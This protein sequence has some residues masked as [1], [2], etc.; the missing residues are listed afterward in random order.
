MNLLE[1]QQRANILVQKVNDY[2]ASLIGTEIDETDTLN[3]HIYADLYCLRP[4]MK[5]LFGTTVDEKLNRTLDNDLPLR[6]FASSAPAWNSTFNLLSVGALDPIEIEPEN[7]GVGVFKYTTNIQ[8]KEVFEVTFTGTSVDR[9][10]ALTAYGVNILPY[11][12]YNE[13]AEYNYKDNN[14]NILRKFKDRNPSSGDILSSEPL[15][16]DILLNDICTCTYKFTGLTDT[17][18]QVDITYNIQH[19]T[20][21]LT[22]TISLHRNSVPKVNY[23][24]I[25]DRN[26]NISK[27]PAFTITSKKCIKYL[28]TGTVDYKSDQHEFVQDIDMWNNNH[29]TT[30][31]VQQNTV[32]S[33]DTRIKQGIN[34]SYS[35]NIADALV[36]ESQVANI[37][38][39]NT[40]HNSTISNN[41]ITVNRQVPGIVCYYLGNDYS[42]VYTATIPYATGTINSVNYSTPSYYG[43][44]YRNDDISKSQVGLEPGAECCRIFMPGMNYTRGMLISPQQI[45][46]P[47]KLVGDANLNKGY[48]WQGQAIYHE[49][50]FKNRR[51][52]CSDLGLDFVPTL[53]NI[54]DNDPQGLA[55]RFALAQQKPYYYNRPWFNELDD[56]YGQNSTKL[57]NFINNNSIIIPETTTKN[58]L[59]NWATAANKVSIDYDTGVMTIPTTGQDYVGSWIS[60]DKSIIANNQLTFIID[61][62]TGSEISYGQYIVNFGGMFYINLE[63]SALRTRNWGASTWVTFK[64]GITAN[65]HYKI[66]VTITTGQQ[67]FEEINSDGTAT[68]LAVLDDTGVNFNTGS[69]FLIGNSS[70]SYFFRGSINL[71]NT[72]VNNNP[73]IHEVTVNPVVFDKSLFDISEG[74]TLSDEGILSPITSSTGATIINENNKL[75][76]STTK[77][78]EIYSPKIYTS[79]YFNS[80]FQI[81]ASNNGYITA[82]VEKEADR[83]GAQVRCQLINYLFF[84]LSVYINSSDINWV[85]FKFVNDVTSKTFKVYARS[86]KTE[87]NWQLINDGVFTV[88]EN[89]EEFTLNRYELGFA[90][91]DDNLKKLDL[92]PIKL[93]VEGETIF[94]ASSVQGITPMND[95][96]FYKQYKLDYNTWANAL[97]KPL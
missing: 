21:G 29:M 69:P 53:D 14:S 8:P 73:I 82:R 24:T 79:S 23:F 58:E 62:T 83:A 66:K 81:G 88:D 77:N 43:A 10:I 38:K 56:L 32:T 71:I 86:D 50:V 2:E 35:S 59:Q 85:Q 18:M 95:E 11:G 44:Y 61:F 70:D 46:Q 17:T 5:L 22:E 16:E 33:R 54:A 84:D 90:D 3:Q 75:D 47:D 93:I 25:V 30:L 6:V 26:N 19:V 55:T 13:L 80:P 27:Y 52:G 89:P 20:T 87:N 7:I 9:L 37:F 12:D 72:T 40:T 39:W 78:F 48:N 57:V 94:S 63:N 68:T 65:S 96:Q 97:D 74:V 92:S 15:I 76:I 45:W 51:P 91:S 67:K 60:I 4:V 49:L 28:N 42:G 41:I 34:Y 1:L 31:D 36:T 64:S